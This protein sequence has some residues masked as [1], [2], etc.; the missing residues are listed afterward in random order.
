MIAISIVVFFLLFFA[1][2]FVKIIETG[3]MRSG[4]I[5]IGVLTVNGL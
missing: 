3:E 2:S 4:M 5:P 1:P